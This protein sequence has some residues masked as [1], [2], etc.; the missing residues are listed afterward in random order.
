MAFCFCILGFG[1]RCLAALRRTKWAS[2]CGSGFVKI[3][4]LNPATPVS[5]WRVV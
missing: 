4:E 2:H 3:G 5:P 1:S